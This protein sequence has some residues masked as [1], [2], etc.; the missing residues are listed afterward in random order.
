[1]NKTLK[2]IFAVLCL[3]TTLLSLVA[4][5]GTSE[6]SETED[7]YYTVTFNSNGGTPVESIKV[8]GGHHAHAPASP[9]LENHV[10]CRWTLNGSP[11]FFDVKEITQDTTLDALWIAADLLFA[12]DPV[13]GGIGIKE[14]KQQ[15]SLDTLVIPSVV[16][17]KTVVSILDEGC[18]M[19]H[20]G[21]ADL[22]VIPDTVTSVGK[23]AFKGITVTKLDFT[24][25]ISSLGESAF[26]NCETLTSIKLGT[27]MEAIPFRCFNNC[28]ALKT[29]DLPEGIKTI[30]E[31]AFEDCSAMLTV[32]LPST[33]TAIE[34]SAFDGASIKTIFFKGSEAQFDAVDIAD[35]NDCMLDAKVYFYAAEKPT[36]DGL[37]WHYDKSGA[38]V[39]W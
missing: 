20:D 2:R 15:L 19:V 32:V 1:M 34:N 37:Y 26:E 29:I 27:G 17:G 22:I 33:I 9:T 23:K 24:G 14:I 12:L 10:F 36:D 8:K 38:P 6:S 11:Y 30:Q 5:G 39:T 25:A 13:E 4:C 28:K 31:N 21:Y 3:C 7:V 18:L 35:G 16:N